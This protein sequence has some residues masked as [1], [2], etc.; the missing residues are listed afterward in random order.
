MFKNISETLG[1]ASCAT[2]LF[3]PHFEVI[4]DLLLNRRTA[5]WN[6]F[7]KWTHA[8]DAMKPLKYMFVSFQFDK[9][10]A[11]V[12]KQLVDGHGYCPR[13]HHNSTDAH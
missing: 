11:N 9:I 13:A 6:L 2:F 7:V 10:Y 1:C 12:L 5:T 3:L 8:G 4:C